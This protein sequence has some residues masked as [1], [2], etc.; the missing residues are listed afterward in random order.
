M[1]THPVGVGF[2]R[3]IAIS[4]ATD[5]LNENIASNCPTHTRRM[6][7]R[8]ISDIQYCNAILMPLFG[9]F[10]RFPTIDSND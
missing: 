10:Q 3:C 8:I 7:V 1:L 4:V 6:R 9:N 2:S 5:T